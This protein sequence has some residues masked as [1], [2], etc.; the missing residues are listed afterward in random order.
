MRARSLILVTVDCL[1]ADRIGFQGYAHPLTPFL[2]SITEKSAVFSGA[3][4]AGAPTYFSFPSI[5]ASR[6]PL[7]L[8]REVLGIAPGEPT[9]ATVL[10]QSG[11]NT[12][13]FV[14][15]NPYLS[16]RFGY[17]QGFDLFSDFL[18]SDVMGES[19]R[20]LRPEDT[21]W[22]ELNRYLQRFSHTTK[23]T[24]AVYDE[25][26]FQYCQWRSGREPVSVDQLRRYPAADVVV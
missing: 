3:V 14:A 12:A 1:R 15:A 11:Y 4:V 22:A 17:G 18:K 24:A 2:G 25:L 19:V 6:Y 5:M 23:G 10:R 20:P 26:Y 16:P 7:D 8:G 21:T 13:A 9:L